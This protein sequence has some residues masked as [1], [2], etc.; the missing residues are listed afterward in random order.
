MARNQTEKNRTVLFATFY[1]VANS[2]NEAQNKVESS[3]DLAYDTDIANIIIP[4]D[5]KY[6]YLKCFLSSSL[7]R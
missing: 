6:N 4:G 7:W 3:L 1:R 5:F 2:N